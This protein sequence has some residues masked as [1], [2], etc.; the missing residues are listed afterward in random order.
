MY[1]YFHV[2]FS[3]QNLFVILF[4]LP[5]VSLFLLLSYVN[6]TKILNFKIERIKFDLN[7]KYSPLSLIHSII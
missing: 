6:L 4:E 5:S 7:S 1:V 2:L 3:S